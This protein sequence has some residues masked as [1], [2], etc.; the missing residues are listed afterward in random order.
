MLGTELAYVRD[1]LKRCSPEERLFAAKAVKVHPK[2]IKRIV[3]RST[4]NPSAMTVGKL[5]MHFRTQEKR[6]TDAKC[7][8]EDTCVHSPSRK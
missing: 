4:E 3:E 2:T 1:Q 5:A 7:R 8:F 6:G